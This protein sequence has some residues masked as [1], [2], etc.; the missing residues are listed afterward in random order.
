MTKYVHY[1]TLAN[2]C[3][4]LDKKELWATSIRYLNDQR[5]LDDALDV[6]GELLRKPN[7]K[8][9]EIDDFV[10]HFELIRSIVADAAEHKLFVISFSQNDLLSQW[11]GYSPNND[12]YAIEFDVD[13]IL[14][15]DGSASLVQCVYEAQ[16]KDSLV[17]AFL[18]EHFEE[19]TTSRKH[20]DIVEFRNFAAEALMPLAARLKDKAFDEER[21]QRIIVKCLSKK[22]IRYRPGQ[23]HLLPYVA[24]PFELRHVKSIT[25]GPTR[26]QA[27]AVAS[28]ESLL[29]KLHYDDHHSRGL[30]EV[31]G[32]EYEV[33]KVTAS[34]IPYRV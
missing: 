13:D 25:V 10:G 23:H 26:H 9:S 29:E 20:K 15:K 22:Q 33:P 2:L 11:R 1:T 16:E 24:L 18:N 17:R 4:I 6:V 14:P 27:L 30:D 8:V 31:F 7:R 34:E 21:E 32:A 5:E 19:F 12:G 28:L 3:S